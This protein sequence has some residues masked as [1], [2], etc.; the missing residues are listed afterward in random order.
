VGLRSKEEGEREIALRDI[1]EEVD[2]MNRL[3]EDLLLLSRLDAKRL[4]LDVE[5]VFLP[6]LLTGIAHQMGKVAAGKG[7]Q[8]MNE[9]KLA[10]VQADR[11][12][13]RQVLL[14][15]LDNALRFTPAGGSVRMGAEEKG[16]TVRLWVADSGV[17][18]AATHL[19]HLFE[20]FYQVPGQ[21]AEGRGNGL[22]L[23]I[24]RGLV[25]AQGGKIAVTSEV[26]KGTRVE[27]RLTGGE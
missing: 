8:L 16:H 7:V 22:G 12:R 1:V 6:E 21:P 19:P 23:A 27:V 10:T 9:G 3:V 5:S 17:G 18:I 13:L 11:T 2:Y 24:A 4:K 25:E 26:G 14:I 15:L 20:R